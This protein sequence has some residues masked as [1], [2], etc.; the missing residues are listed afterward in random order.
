M[1]SSRTN[2]RGGIARAFIQTED[3]IGQARL[4]YLLEE[5]LDIGASHFWGDSIL[6]AEGFHR[7]G[8]RHFVPQRQG[9]DLCADAVQ[10]KATPTVDVH[11]EPA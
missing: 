6:F 11:Q 1:K 2:L 10:L 4:Q 7:F 3:G 8:D 5:G 9:P